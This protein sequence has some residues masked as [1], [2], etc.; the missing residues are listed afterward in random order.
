MSWNRKTRE[1]ILFSGYRADLYRYEKITL[2]KI[3]EV[4]KTRSQQGP[5]C[6]KTLPPLQ[7]PYDTNAGTGQMI[8]G[9]NYG[10]NLYYDVVIA[11]CGVVVFIRPSA[12]RRIRKY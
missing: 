11:G 1:D 10:E 12:C 3:I 2:D 7:K 9:H 6:Q 4:L 5:K 8:R